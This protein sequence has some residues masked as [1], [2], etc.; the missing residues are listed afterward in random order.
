MEKLIRVN[1]PVP[2]GRVVL[3]CKELNG[4]L[5]VAT[6]V[7]NDTLLKL[8]GF[9]NLE[10]VNRPHM[11]I[12]AL[13]IC[14]RDNEFHFV[15]DKKPTLSAVSIMDFLRTF[16]TIMSSLAMDIIDKFDILSKAS[17]TED[18]NTKLYACLATEWHTTPG[19]VNSDVWL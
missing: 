4:V 13:Q 11:T 2:Q 7:C 9:D 18:V 14:L 3:Q 15:V 17:S 6:L 16:K 5:Y 10:L 12:D 1:V 19:K 8:G